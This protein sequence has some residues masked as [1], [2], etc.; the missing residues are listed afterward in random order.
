VAVT[1]EEQGLYGSRHLAELAKEENWNIVA[2]LNNDMIGNSLS[3]GTNLRDNT[4]V[5]V[6]S[7]ATLL[8]NRGRSKMRKLTN[9][10]N[11]SPSRLLARYIK[12]SY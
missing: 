6:F 8:R 12:N 4:K 5:R 11:D 10:D 2:M 1:G 7:E 9:R 3:S